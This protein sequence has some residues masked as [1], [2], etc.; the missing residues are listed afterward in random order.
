MH[1]YG[2]PSFHTILVYYFRDVLARDEPTRTWCG[3]LPSW[4][5]KIKTLEKIKNI[6]FILK[7]KTKILQFIFLKSKVAKILPKIFLGEMIN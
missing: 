1:T 6:D 7:I 2:F 4:A 5:P 3:P